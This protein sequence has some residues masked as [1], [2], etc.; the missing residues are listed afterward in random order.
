M[1]KLSGGG[2][3]P[4]RPGVMQLVRGF[5]GSTLGILLL[6]YLAASTGVPWLMAPFGATCALLFAVPASP[7]AQPRNV[8]GGHLIAAAVGMTALYTLGD[9]AIVMSVAVGLAILLMQ[10]TR[11]VH[12]PAGANPIV[13]ILAG[14]Q[15][16]NW[17]FL[18]T[19][20]LLGSVAL[21][22]LATLVNNSGTEQ[23]WPHY[24]HGYIRRK[25]GVKG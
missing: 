1:K 25:G 12:P 13:I 21:V 20:V 6:G 7:L 3:L 14:Q 18:L 9:S 23:R 8:I 11:T 16:M 5:I 19:P 15:V 17:S 24:W 10:V 2:Q 22:I 4:P